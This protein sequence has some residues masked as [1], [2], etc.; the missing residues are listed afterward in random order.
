[1]HTSGTHTP[2]PPPFNPTLPPCCPLPDILIIH[3]HQS[4]L[5][6]RNCIVRSRCSTS[7]A[8]APQHLPRRSS[9]V[10]T[11]SA[12]TLPHPLQPPRPMHLRA[13]GPAA[14]AARPTSSSRALT[15][16]AS[17]TPTC[18]MPC[19]HLLKPG[20]T[21][22]SYLASP[23]TPAM[24]AIAPTPS[25]PRT[26]HHASAALITTHPSPSAAMHHA[27]CHAPCTH[28]THAAAVTCA[29]VHGGPA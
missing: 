27:Q 14:V 18:R 29:L 25:S 11:P 8:A 24:V 26:H 2:P 20:G 13:L 23:L 28:T 10:A 9:L 16:A 21:P 7:R 4:S 3:A 5:L 19:L 12:G 22:A 15:P 6:Y 1:M 17:G